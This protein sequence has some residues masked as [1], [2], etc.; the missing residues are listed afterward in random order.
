MGIMEKKMETPIM[1]YMGCRIWSIWGSSFN[2]PKATFYLL[3]VRSVTEA[4]P[5]NRLGPEV[6]KAPEHSREA[7]GPGKSFG[8]LRR[9]GKR[10]AG[11]MKDDTWSLDYSSH[12]CALE[13]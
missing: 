2:K 3:K 5:R 13:A 4:P 1:G 10:F 8:R 11:V 12:N 9:H 6:S 7:L